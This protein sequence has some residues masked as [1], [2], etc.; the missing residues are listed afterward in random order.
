MSLNVSRI[1]DQG[2]AV[3]FW[4]LPAQ[5]DLPAL[6]EG[7]EE[8]GFGSCVPSPRTNLAVLREAVT[9]VSKTLKIHHVIVPLDDKSGFALVQS[10]SEGMA[11]GSTWGKV[12]CVFKIQELSPGTS[13]L[14]MDPMDRDLFQEVCQAYAYGRDKITAPMAGKCLV[15]VCKS[16]N[17]ACLRPSGGI[18]WM[19]E[20]SIDT[21]GFVAKAFNRAGKESTIYLIRHK[22]DFDSVRAVYDGI[23]AETET[24][25]TRIR[26]EILSGDLGEQ[27]LLWREQECKR[28]ADLLSQ[29]EEWT[30]ASFEHTKKLAEEMTDAQAFAVL[31]QA[32]APELV[33]A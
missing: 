4:R 3:T 26:A 9:A 30:G 29:Y 12:S 25:L 22:L 13:H 31:H 33:P 8:I 5:L 11:P 16:L 15:E 6:K 28:M 1:P 21:W 10:H 24:E 20:S 2:G 14:A 7:L 23:M 27:A 17:G 32:I 19:H 18:Y